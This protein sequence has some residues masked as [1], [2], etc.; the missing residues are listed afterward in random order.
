MSATGLESAT[1]PHAVCV[2]F[3]LQS[4]IGAM[5]KLAKLLHRKGFHISFVNT[6]FNHRRLARARGLE[7]ADGTPSDFRFLTIPDGLPPSDA[8][9]TQDI[10]TLCESTRSHMVAP[11]GDLVSSLVSSPS[12]PPVTC[13]VSDGVVTLT[14]SPAASKFGIP[15]IHLFTVAG[16]T[17]MAVK[18]LRALRENGLALLTATTTDESQFMNAYGNT[19]IDWIPGLK[20]MRVR[21]MP[22]FFRIPG[23]DDAVFDFSAD[24]ADRMG[25]ATATIVHTF[26]ALEADVL[27]ALS[28]MVPRVYAVGP[29]HL[30][31]DRI[32]PEKSFPS[33]HIECNL[34]EEHDE[35]LQWLDTKEP[36]SVI[37]VNFGSVAVLTHQQLVEF[38]MGL[39]NSNQCFLW[40]LRPDA[41]NGD[42]AILPEEFV[43]ETRERGFLSGWCSQERVLYHPSVG[44]FLTHCGW[45]STI[46]SLSAGVPM[47][48]W[49]CSGDQQTNR[50]YICDDWGVGL[51][52]D[53]DVKRDEVERLVRELME[54]EVGKKMRSKAMEW[55]KLAEEAAGEEG[56]SSMNLDKLLDQ[57]LST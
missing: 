37:Y 48:C 5:L 13:I 15:L 21:D 53:G 54:G 18:H 52:M 14:T 56:S 33:K 6:E 47:L 46:E 29:L 38:A 49:P 3:P 36:K 32:A 34:L 20:N 57:V 55:K 44:G 40:I 31:I 50:K 8:D 24:V 35:C 26:E 4:H 42:A 12:V 1:K 17:L 10:A 25:D 41:V 11:F 43:E 39:A 51:E 19:P 16:C 30:M 27:H 7:F 22:N 28:S 23:S 2:P 9:A 45:N